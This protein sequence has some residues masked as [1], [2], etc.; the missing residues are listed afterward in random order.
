MGSQVRTQVHYA[1]S[2]LTVGWPL[3]LWEEPSHAD[4]SDYRGSH[5]PGIRRHAPPHYDASNHKPGTKSHEG[6]C[7]QGGEDTCQRDPQFSVLSPKFNISS[8]SIHLMGALAQAK[9]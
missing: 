5:L 4:P 2:G 1:R 6:K 3:R 8:C 9:T 7:R